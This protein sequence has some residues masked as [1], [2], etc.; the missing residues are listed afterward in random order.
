M[1][2]VEEVPTK[3]GRKRREGRGLERNGQAGMG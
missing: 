1:G 3:E 2:L